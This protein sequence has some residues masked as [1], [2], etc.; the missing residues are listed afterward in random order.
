MS[1]PKK[2]RFGQFVQQ[3]QEDELKVLIRRLARLEGLGDVDR[4]VLADIARKISRG[5]F[6]SAADAFRIH[7]MNYIVQLRV[8][9]DKTVDFDRQIQFSQHRPARGSTA[10]KLV[11]KH[12]ESLKLTNI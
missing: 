2:A 1:T 12:Q 3:S 9:F 7:F 4:A 11:L 10:R 8:D 6:S 5:K